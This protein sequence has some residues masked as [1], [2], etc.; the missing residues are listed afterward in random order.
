MSSADDCTSTNC[1]ST[2]HRPYWKNENYK[3]V[4]YMNVQTDKLTQ[5][6]RPYVIIINKKERNCYI[7]DFAVSANRTMKIK[8]TEKRNY[9]DFSAN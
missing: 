7:L 8:D 2:N 5:A 4:W 3:I 9:V 6:R 1:S